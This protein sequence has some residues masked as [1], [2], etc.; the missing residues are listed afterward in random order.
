MV[1]E[2]IRQL[3]QEFEGKFKRQLTVD[4]KR[5]LDLAEKFLRKK[6]AK[7]ATAD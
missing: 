1:I 3:R 7:G 6:A 4:E 5:I 2:R